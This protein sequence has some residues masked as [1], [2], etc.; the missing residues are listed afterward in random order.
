MAGICWALRAFVT[1]WKPSPLAWPRLCISGVQS[2]DM[3]LGQPY[4]AE[5]QESGGR[6]ASLSLRTVT[7]RALLAPGGGH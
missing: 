7:A 4:T 5:S 2:P 6:Q 3:L 1:N